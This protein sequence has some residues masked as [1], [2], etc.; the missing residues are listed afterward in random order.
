M[1]KLDD[2][3]L[4]ELDKQN[5]RSEQIYFIMNKLDDEEKKN[6]FLAY[7]IENRHILIHLQFYK[8]CKS[9]L[10]LKN[11]LILHYE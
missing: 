1:D 6:L 9:K 5:I 2:L 8:S 10:D 7:M 11:D 4:N 3:I